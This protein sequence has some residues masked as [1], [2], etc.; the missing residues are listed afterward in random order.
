MS[1][2]IT[3]NLPDDT[4]KRAE[5]YAAYAQ[6]DLSDIIAA[7][8]ASSLPSLEVID[9]LRSIS[10]LPDAEIVALTEL[11]MEPEADHRL[12]VLLQQQQAVQV[13]EREHAEL[14]A[15]M[16]EYE[17]DLLRQSQGLAEAVRRGLRPQL[18]P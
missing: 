13:S 1:T 3:V 9:E 2:R 5:T 11:K 12:S 17:I 8:L 7:A 6:R 15:L 4:F 14:A 18:A 10:K 16:R